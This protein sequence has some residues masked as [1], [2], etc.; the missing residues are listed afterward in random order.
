M[1]HVHSASVPEEVVAQLSGHPGD[2][3]FCASA[4]LEP[5]DG[6][7]AQL[8]A[9]GPGEAAGRL[10]W[11]LMETLFGHTGQAIADALDT[12]MAGLVSCYQPLAT[13]PALPKTDAVRT[14]TACVVALA[15]RAP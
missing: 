14:V 4:S 13:V 8:R 1:P 5:F 6:A 12:Y 11:C 3:A 15:D 7:L 9:S 10:R 2:V